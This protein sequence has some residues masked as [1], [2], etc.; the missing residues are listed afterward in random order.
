MLRSHPFIGRQG[1]LRFCKIAA[2]CAVLWQAFAQAEPAP[3]PDATANALPDLTVQADRA[4][5]PGDSVLNSG[6][7]E[8]FVGEKV[9]HEI[10]SPV[11]DYGIVANF[12]PSFVSSSPNGPG[13][14]AAKGQTL[15]GFVDG[16]FNVTMDGIP[17]GDPDNFS[18]HSTSFFPDA[19]LDHVLVDRSP[20]DAGDLGYASFGGSIN[21]Y[22]E[23]LTAE[24]RARVFSSYGSF[25]T[26]LAGA[27][28]STA[29]P[30]S[31]GQSGIL[32]T[33]EDAHSDGAMSYSPGDKS[34]YFVKGATILGDVHITGVLSYDRYHFYNPGSIT[35]TDL[36]AFGSS[37]GYN[38]QPGTPNYYGYNATERS[39]DFDYVR[40]EGSLA[41]GW[42]F[43]DK[44]Y[45][46]SYH[47]QGLSLKGDQT[48]S[49]LTGFPDIPS[50]DIAGRVTQED[51]RTSG[52]DVRVTHH[53]PI[54]QLLLGFWA[55]HSWQTEHRDGIDFTTG[56]PYDVNKKAHSPVYFDF[57][58]H[59]DTIQPYAEYDWQATSALSLRFGLRYRDVTRD[60]DA[61]VIQN[62]LPGTDGTV[63]RTVNSTLPS[64]DAV[65]RLDEG[66]NLSAQISKGS[67]VP[68]QAFFYTSSPSASNQVNP[69]N[70]VTEQLGIVRQTTGYG[71]GF[72]VYHISFDNY[73]STITQNGDTLYVN[74]GNVLYRG[75][76]LE[77]HLMLGAGFTLVGNASLMRATFQD[78]GIT[79]PI[80]QAGDTIPYAPTHTGLLGFIYRQGFWSGSLLAKFVGTEYQGKNGS[81]DGSAYRVNAYSFTN[82]TVTRNLP[83]WLGT[84]NVR[85]TLAVNNLWNSNAITDNAGPSIEGPN[86]VNVLPRR[87][88]MLTV[89]ADW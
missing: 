21:L 37:F 41:G 62:Y 51:Y 36:A 23:P 6:A 64:F 73:V 89:V 10:A 56:L 19:V 67:L 74:D 24:P 45:T 13:F 27:T 7:P 28:A 61:T 5:I 87:N 63:S 82:A 52:N 25:N 29:A 8:S 22:S 18:H 59:L 30:Q 77:G 35:T 15:R 80:Q 71:I 78:S 33:V 84:H 17:F 42:A 70:T 3:D 76:E 12:T 31:S 65:Y 72:D 43:E 88:Y 2:A 44:L 1:K 26:V 46:F 54:G 81:A 85:L 14:D 83:D 86:L 66:T 39:S 60:F 68:S 75:A 58:A 53:D 9:I 69:E 34:D 55:E 79:S 57:D 32:A 20:G 47:N 4:Q 50:T 49:P 48:A 40:F 38:D 11:G 16:Q